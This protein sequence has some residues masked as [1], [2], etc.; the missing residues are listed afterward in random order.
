MENIF[1]NIKE[2]L[3]ERCEALTQK[4]R[5]TVLVILSAVYLILTIAVIASVFLPDGNRQERHRFENL[6][7]RNAD[8]LVMPE[9]TNENSGQTKTTEYE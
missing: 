5:K 8:T 1:K 2:K 4:Q 7:D 9:L 6:I 3:K